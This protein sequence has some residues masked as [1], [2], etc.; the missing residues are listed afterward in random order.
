MEFAPAAFDKPEVL[1]QQALQALIGHSA[2][3]NVSAACLLRSEPV[4][5][6][7]GMAMEKVS[8]TSSYERLTWRWETICMRRGAFRPNPTSL[9]RQ[10]IA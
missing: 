7:A 10:H 9:A 1:H 8:V 5:D 4:M 3:A 6:V 2:R